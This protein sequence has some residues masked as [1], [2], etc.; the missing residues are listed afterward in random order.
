METKQLTVADYRE[1]GA[2]L[3][4]MRKY[5]I[6]LF[7]ADIVVFVLLTLTA[8]VINL[9]TDSEWEKRTQVP[10]RYKEVSVDEAITRIMNLSM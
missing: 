9:N 1:T 2:I 5:L 6:V 10:A 3:D 7:I 4:R 8:I